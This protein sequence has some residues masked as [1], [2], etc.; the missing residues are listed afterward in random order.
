VAIG[1]LVVAIGHLAVA[2]GHPVRLLHQQVLQATPPSPPHVYA[3]TCLLFAWNI[4]QFM[5]QSLMQCFD[6]VATCPSDFAKYAKYA[7][8]A[9][10]LL[11]RKAR[12]QLSVLVLQLYVK[13]DCFHWGCLQGLMQRFGM[14]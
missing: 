3:F 4:E 13:Q 6:I 7:L 12:Q 9:T 11:S 14:P 1:H 2:I 8:P 5:Q 10:V